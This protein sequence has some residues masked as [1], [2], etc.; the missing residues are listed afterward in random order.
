MT[1]FA[2]TLARLREELGGKPIE[3]APAPTMAMI[4]VGWSVWERCPDGTYYDPRGGIVA[5]VVPDGAANPD[6]GEVVDRYLVVRRGLHGLHWVSLR[7]DQL[8]AVHDG[9]RP[10]AHSI[11]GVCQIAAR[12]VDRV[13]SK[14]Q[15]DDEKALELLSLG[16]RLM[17]VLARPDAVAP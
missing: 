10:N 13:L 7:A 6:T 11:R 2:D 8:E 17:A 3:R 4:G 14:R 1:A 15:P 5:H 9:N 12:E 16:A